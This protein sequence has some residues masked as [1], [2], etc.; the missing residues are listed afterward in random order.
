MQ[1]EE[2]TI[3]QLQEEIKRRKRLIPRK[4]KGKHQYIQWESVVTYVDMCANINVYSAPL[5]KI[6]FTVKDTVY[7]KVFIKQGCHFT[8]KNMPKLGDKVLLEYKVG[9]GY[10]CGKNK[11]KII[12]IID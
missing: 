3:E 10:T 7:N 5:Y 12:K 8:K 2:Y 11:S 1:L 6:P 4:K 9:K